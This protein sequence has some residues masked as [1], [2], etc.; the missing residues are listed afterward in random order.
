MKKKSILLLLLVFILVA[1]IVYSRLDTTTDV[2]RYQEDADFTN[3][4]GG[5]NT[6][7]HSF[8]NFTDGDYSTY[9]L[10]NGTFYMNY[11]KKPDYKETSTFWQVKHNTSSGPIT[12]NYSIPAP[13]WNYNQ[14]KLILKV[15]AT[16]ATSPSNDRYC[17]S[18]TWTRIGSL[19]S[20]AALYEESMWWD[21]KGRTYN[22]SFGGLT[23]AAY[24]TFDQATV[25]FTLW[26][27]DS[28]ADE[29]HTTF[30]CS[31]HTR[32]N[33]TANYKVNITSM[34]VTNGSYTNAS[35]SFN[36][37]DRIWWYWSCED[38]F[39]RVIRNSSV[40]IFDV[41]LIYYKLS[42]G[43]SQVI[44]FSLDSGRIETAGGVIAKNMTI[45]NAL[46]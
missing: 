18:G 5:H 27:N 20:A 16:N 42:L 31:I 24:V 22:I 25:N 2:Y 28:L 9:A 32:Q 11:T 46:V 38:N 36:D 43:T 10:V 8:G 14:T 37:G 4:S 23:P 15:N 7:Y 29:N 30:N 41:D 1:I 3:F 39:T 26:I 13:C 19:H 6:S 21:I 35:V 40:R 33:R 34:T 44:N 17:Y 45:T 12:I